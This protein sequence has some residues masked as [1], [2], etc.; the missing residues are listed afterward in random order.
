M[1]QG[2]VEFS[3]GQPKPTK[4]TKKCEIKIERKIIKVSKSY[5]KE[6]SLHRPR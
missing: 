3:E 4:T 1:T 5:L 2:N 6:E